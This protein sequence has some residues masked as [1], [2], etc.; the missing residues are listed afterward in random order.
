MIKT[1]TFENPLVF[2]VCILIKLEDCFCNVY[3]AIFF[4][5]FFG[6]MGVKFRKCLRNFQ[7]EVKMLTVAYMGEKGVKNHQNQ[8]HVVYGWTL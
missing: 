5:F 7:G 8:A 3:F 1:Y 6:R 2:R 4:F